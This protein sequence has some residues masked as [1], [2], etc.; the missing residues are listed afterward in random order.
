MNPSI[1]KFLITESIHQSRFGTA[2]SANW[3]SVKCEKVARLLAGHGSKQSDSRLKRTGVLVNR[4]QNSNAHLVDVEYGFLSGF[5]LGFYN[6][7]VREV[8]GAIKACE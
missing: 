1:N 7:F 5:V 3:L 8:D 4:V 2:D 6:G